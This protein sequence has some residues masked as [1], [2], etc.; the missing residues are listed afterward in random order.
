MNELIRLILPCGAGIL[1]GAIFFGGLWWTIHHGLT[2]PRPATWFLGSLLLRT[3][4]AVA[5]FYLVS[6]GDFWRL[7]ACLLGFVMARWLVTWL[8]RPQEKL[9]TSPEQE[10]R[11]ASKS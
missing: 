7:A 4:I 1:L 11:H 10:V 8:T 9:Q 6:H 3:S 2:S 5:G